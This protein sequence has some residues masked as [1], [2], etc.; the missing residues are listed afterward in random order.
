M[1]KSIWDEDDIGKE[2]FK[3]PSMRANWIKKG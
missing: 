2:L 3:V 1:G